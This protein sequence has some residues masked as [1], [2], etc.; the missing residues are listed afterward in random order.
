MLKLFHRQSAEE[1]MILIRSA[2]AMMRG[3]EPVQI[4]TLLQAYIN[5]V[6]S[7]ED[8]TRFRLKQVTDELGQQGGLLSENGSF[9]EYTW[10]VKASAVE[11]YCPAMLPALFDT[12]PNAGLEV[13]QVL[14]PCPN[15]AIDFRLPTPLAGMI[16]RQWRVPFLIYG[17][18]NA[19]VYA[20]PFQYQILSKD[21]SAYWVS[22]SPRALSKCSIPDIPA[23]R[24]DKNIVVVQDRFDFSNLCHFI[25]DG[26]TRILHY[27]KTFG[28]S[29]KDLF[30]LGSVPDEYQNLICE[31]LVEH[32]RIPLE[33]LHFPTRAH[34][35]TTSEKVFWFSDQIEGHGHPAQM[36]HPRSISAL[37]E[38]CAKI[39]AVLNPARRIYISRGDADRRRIANEDELVEQLEA[40]GFVSVKL[41][42]LSAA[43]QIGLFREADIV[44]GPHGMGLTHIIAGQNLG[45]VI[46]LFHPNAGTD[47]YA[48]IARAAGM[49]YDFVIGTI[50]SD[51]PNDFVVDVRHVL[52]LLGPDDRSIR[53][54]IWNRAANLIPASRSFLGFSPAHSAR[55]EVSQERM[56]WDQ[57][58]RRHSIHAGTT[59]AGRWPHIL[60]W[61]KQIYTA[62]CWV[63][64]PKKFEGDQVHVEIGEWRA[65]TL[66]AANLQLRETWQ[67]IWF[68]AEAPA[69]DRC[70]VELHIHGP[71]GSAVIS[72]CWQF[73]D[74][75][76]PTAYVATG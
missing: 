44:V 55:I 24:I 72:T 2:F 19:S 62:S 41:R 71:A 3:D 61:S 28:A 49:D 8:S 29:D 34:L 60:I 64:I 1:A 42:G 68:T 35:I 74:G 63:W 37:A 33:N 39:P 75:T 26:V 73:E 9:F 66:Q 20:H 69:K 53:Q 76:R 48:L 13:T 12:R 31:A 21:R 10:S 14:E 46:E 56:M 65:L 32:A 6:G 22:G 58:S 7:Y 57:E 15:D 4:G 52:D 43:E 50:V 16:R 30:I 11:Q 5:G 40:R 27:V 18:E 38:L 51:T 67:Q 17:T 47:A 23:A 70:W 36:A 25:F 59:E 45:R 54:P